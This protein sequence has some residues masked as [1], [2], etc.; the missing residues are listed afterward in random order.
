MDA[1]PLPRIDE[2]IN[3]MSKHRFFSKYDLKNAYHQIPLHPNDKKL[4]AFEANGKMLQFKRIPFGLTNAVGAFQ[5]TLAQIIKE[6]GLVGIYPYL[7][8][9]TIAGN[10]NDEL[11]DRL[12]KFESALKK[13]KMTLNE[14]RTVREVKKIT[15]LGYEIENGS[16]STD[17][18]R[19]QPLL[20]LA[21]PKTSKELKQIRGLFAYHAK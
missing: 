9:V 5:R 18:N 20:E 13:R 21:E 19:L 8:D 7:D 12:M 14:D 3:E 2:L 15:F 10:T 1:F 17:K 16:I 11:R 4:T 6:D